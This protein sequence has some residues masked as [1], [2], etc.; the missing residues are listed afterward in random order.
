[1]VLSQPGTCLLSQCLAL[2]KLL[3]RLYPVWFTDLPFHPGARLGL[4]LRL[5]SL[6]GTLQLKP[7][8]STD[9]EILPYLVNCSCFS[10]ADKIPLRERFCLGLLPKGFPVQKVDRPMD[11]SCAMASAGAVGHCQPTEINKNTAKKMRSKVKGT[12]STIL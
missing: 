5:N 2:L 4:L 1:M 11:S 12:A 10:S 8:C 7:G 6:A 9:L 3:H